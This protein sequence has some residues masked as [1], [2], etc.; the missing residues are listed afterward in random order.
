MVRDLSLQIR[1]WLWSSLFAFAL[2]LSSTWT[3]G[4]TV[5]IHVVDQQGAPVPNAVIMLPDAVPAPIAPK[6]A[7]MDQVERQFRPYVLTVGRGTSVSFPNSDNIR[8]H[9]YSFSSPKVFELKLYAGKPEAPILF[10]RPGIVVL[11]C[12]IHDGMVGYIVVSEGA[13]WAQTD[14][15][16]ITTLEL[17][18]EAT[19]VRVWHPQQKGNLA[20]LTPIL[21]PDSLPDDRFRMPLTLRASETPESKPDAGHSFKYN[22]FKRYGS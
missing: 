11:G 4:R 21:V 20:A 13:V 17:P 15:Q 6:P 16:G 22:R 7:V 3:S 8:H 19:E 5:S 12:N 1:I 10:D 2:C 9:V 18:D 14:E